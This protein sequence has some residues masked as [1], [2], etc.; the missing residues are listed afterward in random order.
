MKLLY[1]YLANYWRLV[2]VALALATINQ[3]FS[4]MDPLIFR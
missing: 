4:L 3:V 1:S 2:G